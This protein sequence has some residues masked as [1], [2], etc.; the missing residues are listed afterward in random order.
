MKRFS[1]LVL[2]VLIAAVPLLIAGQKNAEKG[3]E[4]FARRCEACHG[5]DGEGKP[6]IEKMYNVKMRPL[7]S[8]EVQAKS[9]KELETII[10]K[11][12]K[13]MP[14]VHLNDAE[15]S[16]VVAYLREMAKKKK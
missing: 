3:K 11:G 8:K 13:K 12:Y 1:S 14:P 7:T 2:V 9:D 4:L 10:L 5:K 15:A 16:D 6:Q